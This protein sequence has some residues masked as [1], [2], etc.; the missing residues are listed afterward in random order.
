MVAQEHNLFLIPE[1]DSQVVIPI[2]EISSIELFFLKHRSQ[3]KTGIVISSH[4]LQQ[5]FKVSALSLC[6]SSI[7]KFN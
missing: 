5:K 4:N 1:N 7:N 3:V 6:N 2:N